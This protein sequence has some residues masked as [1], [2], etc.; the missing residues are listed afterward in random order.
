MLRWYV[1]SLVFLLVISPAIAYGVYRYVMINPAEPG[2]FIGRM[3]EK[4]VKRKLSSRCTETMAHYARSV[5]GNTEAQFEAAC[6]CF[7]DRMFE[8]FRDVPPGQL[9][10]VAEEEATG[11]AAEAIFNQC[12]DRAGLN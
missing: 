10:A 11:R 9:D 5:E 2:T 7:T 1:A 3:Y 8:R 6:K 12:V 4:S